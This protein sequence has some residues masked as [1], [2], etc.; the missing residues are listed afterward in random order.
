MEKMQLP[1]IR[2]RMDILEMIALQF[3]SRVG[4]WHIS[5][6]REMLRG[7]FAAFT[8]EIKHGWICMGIFDDRKQAEEA[9]Q[10]LIQEKRGEKYTGYLYFVEAIGLGQIKI[11]FSPEPEKLVS[12][13]LSNSPCELRLLGKIPGD[14]EELKEI[15]SVLEDMHFKGEWFFSTNKVR[16]LLKKKL[17][18][19]QS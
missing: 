18:V 19:Q 2:V 11:G 9:L 16:E 15:H 6:I 12:E 17:N 1:K 14:E 8:K 3:E 10:D 7:N 4:N 13:L 5:T